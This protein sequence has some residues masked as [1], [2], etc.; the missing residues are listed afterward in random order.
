MVFWMSWTTS[1]D[2]GDHLRGPTCPP[3]PDPGVRP[4]QTVRGRSGGSLK[5]VGNVSGVQHGVRRGLHS[6][7]KRTRR[8]RGGWGSKGQAIVEP[9]GLVGSA[10]EKNV[11]R[12]RLWFG[13]TCLPT[14][15][16][17]RDFEFLLLDGLQ[18]LS[19][20]RDGVVRVQKTNCSSAGPKKSRK[21]GVILG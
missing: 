7:A 5:L 6:A 20:V 9:L 12:F 14:K 19:N 1:G 8:I 21:G 3:D 18:L 17:I 11:N 2:L 15:K 4:G 16:S 13:K 10:I